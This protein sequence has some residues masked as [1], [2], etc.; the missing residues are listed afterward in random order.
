[1][2]YEK[3]V[4]AIIIFCQLIY[5]LTGTHVFYQGDL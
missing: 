1:M 5:Y 4:L 3:L 2:N